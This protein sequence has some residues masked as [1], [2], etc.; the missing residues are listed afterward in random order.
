[1]Q[2]HS[3][4]EGTLGVTVEARVR[5]VELPGAKVVLVIQFA[6]LLDALGATPSILAH[7]PAA[8]EVLDRYVLDSTRL[9]PEAARLRDF[10]RGDPGGIL[11]VEFYGDRPDDLPPRLDALERDMRQRGWGYHYY[12]ATGN[13]AQA[14]I[15]KLRKAALGL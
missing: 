2:L 13:D 5:L 15:W 1:A 6:E 14:R 4:L 12:R 3:G 9:N 11:I 8:V 7:R 10:L